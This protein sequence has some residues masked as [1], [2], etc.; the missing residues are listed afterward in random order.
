MLMIAPQ[1]KLQGNFP[2]NLPVTTAAFGGGLPYPRKT[3]HSRGLQRD[4][5]QSPSETTRE[6]SVPWKNW[7]LDR[8][9]QPWCFKD[10]QG[11]SRWI[12]SHRERTFSGSHSIMSN[13]VPSPISGVFSCSQPTLFKLHVRTCHHEPCLSLFR[14][15][16]L[17]R[18][19]YSTYPIRSRIGTFFLGILKAVRTLSKVEILR[20]VNRASKT[21]LSI[22]ADNPP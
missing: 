8:I 16:A 3:S 13:G 6:P 22:Q 14:A 21:Q 20:V 5:K 11:G 4:Q 9:A 12:F 15:E 1:R 10:A 2:P 7:C 19:Y 17:H 18:P